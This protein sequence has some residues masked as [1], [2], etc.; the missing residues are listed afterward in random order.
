MCLPESIITLLGD[1]AAD[2]K[3]PCGLKACFSSI[4]KFENE[5]LSESGPWLQFVYIIQRIK[6]K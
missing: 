5:F 1:T 6:Y 3:K 2:N 4:K